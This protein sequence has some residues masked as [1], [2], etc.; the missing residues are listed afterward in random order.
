MPPPG[1]SQGHRRGCRRRCRRIRRRSRICRRREDVL[2]SA[3]PIRKEDRM[4]GLEAFSCPISSAKPRG[5]NRTGLFIALALAAVIGLLFG[6]HPELDLKLAALFYDPAT[7][8]FPLKF[9]STAA[10]ARDVA[11]WLGGGR[12]PQGV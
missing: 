8:S 1:A 11:M 4:A 5:M 3:F 12:G 2:F 10:F 7:K 9:N 6:I